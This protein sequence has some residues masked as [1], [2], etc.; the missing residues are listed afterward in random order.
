MILPNMTIYIYS[1]LK[2]L[3]CLV[4]ILHCMINL[5]ISCSC[6]RG[7]LL[8]D[9]GGHILRALLRHLPSAEV[10]HLAD[11]QPRQQDHRHHLAGQSGVHQHFHK[12]YIFVADSK[13][14]SHGPWSTVY[15]LR[16]RLRFPRVKD[17]YG[18][19]SRPS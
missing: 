5:H 12:I 6:L 3:L 16:S 11:D 9:L 17:A 8:L 1:F 13:S 4:P 18:E 7:R 19:A 14:L 10:A 2:C 15:G